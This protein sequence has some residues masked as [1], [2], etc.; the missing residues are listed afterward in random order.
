LLLGHEEFERFDVAFG[1]FCDRPLLCVEFFSHVLFE[2]LVGEDGFF[3]G[4]VFGVRFVVH[5]YCGF[6]VLARLFKLL[7]DALL[8][9]VVELV[10]NCAVRGHVL[11]F[12]RSDF[13]SLEGRL[14]RPG[15]LPGSL[16]QDD[17]FE[18]LHGGKVI[19]AV[20]FVHAEDAAGVE[21]VF[22]GLGGVL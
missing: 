7:L 16:A 18:D 11:S 6:Q 1:L 13:L 12:E 21:R 2:L 22:E 19:G 5:F 17:D 9:D 8:H 3:G 14:V 15:H 20:L 10:E 4:E